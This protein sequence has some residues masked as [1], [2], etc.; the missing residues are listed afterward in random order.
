MLTAKGSNSATVTFDGGI[1][2]IERGRTSSAGRGTVKLPVSS[3]TMVTLHPPKTL[4]LGW[5]EFGV[6]GVGAT[7]IRKPKDAMKSENCVAFTGGHLADFEAIRDAVLA[8]K[9]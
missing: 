5:I 6:P 3:I 8:A 4:T 1:V 2:T 7:Q 9:T